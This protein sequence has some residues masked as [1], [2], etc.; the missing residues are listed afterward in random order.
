MAWRC[1]SLAERSRRELIQ[2]GIDIAVPEGR[3]KRVGT[4]PVGYVGQ[5]V[6]DGV[7]KEVIAAVT[8]CP[9]YPTG[10][11]PTRFTQ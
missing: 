6:I 5:G 10:P 11:V 8:P 3:V 9:T 2:R 1:P 7:P 4:G